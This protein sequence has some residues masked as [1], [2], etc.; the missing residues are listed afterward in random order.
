MTMIAVATMFRITPMICRTVIPLLKAT[1]SI[2]RLPV[3]QMAFGTVFRMMMD[4]V[5]ERIVVKKTI[6]AQTAP[7]KPPNR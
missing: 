7:T 1:K 6:D 5:L 4:T 2:T 3:R